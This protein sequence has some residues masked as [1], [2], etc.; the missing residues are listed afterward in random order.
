MWR[1]QACEL[2]TSDQCM[3]A[4]ASFC[5]HCFW[6]WLMC[7]GSPLAWQYARC[8][9]LAPLLTLDRQEIVREGTCL[10]AIDRPVSEC[11]QDAAICNKNKHLDT[12]KVKVLVFVM[13]T[14]YWYRI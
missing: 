1:V 9:D 14:V 3:T 4:A 11:G 2:A 5:W 6:H 8:L 13:L 12:W 7:T 10:P